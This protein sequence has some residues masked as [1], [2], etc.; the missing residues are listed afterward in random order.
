MPVAPWEA[1]LGAS[2]TV[3]TP[4]GSVQLSVPT[5]SSAGRKLRLKGKGIPGAATGDP[6]GDLY[7]TLSIAQPPTATEPEQAAYRELAKAFG[8][9]NPRDSLEA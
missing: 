9:F 5:N 6:A 8:D 1:A 4:D 7:A 3:P 2:I